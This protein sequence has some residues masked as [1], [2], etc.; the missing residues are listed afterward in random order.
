M[1]VQKQPPV[2]FYKNTCSLKF[3]YIHRKTPVLESLFNKVGGLKP[4]NVIE[5][6]INTDIPMN[7]AK[8]LRAPLLR[9]TAFLAATKMGISFFKR[10]STC[11]LRCLIN[12]GSEIFAKLGRRGGG[13]SK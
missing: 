8:F 13:G 9:N 6:D 12:G 11:I 1:K 5:R 2:V 3:H 10:D 7:I 4:C